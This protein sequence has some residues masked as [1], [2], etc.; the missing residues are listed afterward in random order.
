LRQNVAAL[1]EFVQLF[2]TPVLGVNLADKN[3]EKNIS[4]F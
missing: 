2:A 3:G 1:G 4:K